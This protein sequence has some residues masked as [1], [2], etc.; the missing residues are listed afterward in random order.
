M[1]SSALGNTRLLLQIATGSST[2]LLK[3]L[4]AHCLEILTLTLLNVFLDAWSNGVTEE[5]E[6]GH[7]LVVMA[8]PGEQSSSLENIWPG[9][10][11]PDL[12]SHCDFKVWI[13]D[14]L[15]HFFFC[16]FCTRDPQ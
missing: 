15:Y 7:D 5:G 12:P 16:R 3:A 8:E 4:G 6:Q 10:V 13:I 14:G 1:L 2:D 11:P 9:H